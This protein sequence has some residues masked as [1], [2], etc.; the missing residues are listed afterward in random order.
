MKRNLRLKTTRG[1]ALIA[2]LVGLMAIMLTGA[3]LVKMI[4]T[5]HRTARQSHQRLQAMYIADAAERRAR[6]R[7]V[8]DET[9]NGETW[10][11]PAEQFEKGYTGIAT[12]TVSKSDSEE[13]PPTVNIVARY[14]ADANQPAVFRH[15]F[16]FQ[17]PSGDQP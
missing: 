12:I 5:Q 6:I 2:V 13:E 1:A 16:E 15:S 10:N 11:I 4:V 14:P 17:I 9:W 3:A 8:A 7:L